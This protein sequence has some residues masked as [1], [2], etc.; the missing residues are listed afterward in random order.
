MGNR[1]MK[2]Y[3]NIPEVLRQLELLKA[4]ASASS[5]GEGGIQDALVGAL[6]SGRALMKRRIFNNSEDAAGKP[7]GDYHGSK[8]R[9]TKKK[10]SQKREDDEEEKG[11]RKVKRNFNRAIKDDADGTYTEYEKVRLGAGRQINKKDLQMSGSTASSIE[12]VK[13]EGN[14]VVVQITNTENAKIARYQEQQIGNIRAG[15]HATKGKAEP[16]KIFV[17]SQAEFDAV[18]EQGKRLITEVIKSK[19]Q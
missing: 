4:A 17:F 13:V 14:K 8:T 16:A 5:S 6:N 15:Q 1:I 12:V 10:F 2:L 18:D 11:R 19:M 9:L 7:L 3:T